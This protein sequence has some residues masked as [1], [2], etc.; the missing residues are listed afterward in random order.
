MLNYCILDNID[1]RTFIICVQEADE[2]ISSYLRQRYAG[3][4]ATSGPTGEARAEI[5]D[6]LARSAEGGVGLKAPSGVSVEGRGEDGTT[7]VAL[8]STCGGGI[9]GG[10]ERVI[11]RFTEGGNL[12]GSIKV[13]G[14]QIWSRNAADRLAEI[15]IKTTSTFLNV[16]R[17]FSLH[18]VL[19]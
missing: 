3:D 8:R 16:R 7:G 5:N 15:L 12:A 13:P 9:A 17:L 11:S 14:R 10:G 18:N 6:S 2:I 1:L 19:A 4:H